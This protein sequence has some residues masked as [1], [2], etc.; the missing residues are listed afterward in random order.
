MIL[1]SSAVIAIVCREPGW[2]ELLRKIAD[3]TVVAIGT[4]TVAEALLVASVKIG[5]GG[6]ERID[7]FLAGIEAQI[8]PFARQHLLYFHDAFR[9]Y[10]KGKH[11]AALNMGDC[12]SYAVARMARQ[13]LLFVGNDFS[14]TDVERA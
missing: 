11:P 4:P 8:V 9:R 13:P 3:S 5:P 14:Q 7:K 10:G 12:F 1:D 2:D 6:P